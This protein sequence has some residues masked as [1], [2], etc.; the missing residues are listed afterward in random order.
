MSVTVPR[1]IDAVIKRLA[2]AS[3]LSR[4]RY[5]LMLLDAIMQSEARV[6]ARTT[7]RIDTD[8]A[9]LLARVAEARKKYAATPPDDTSNPAPPTGEKSATIYP[10][11]R[12]ARRKKD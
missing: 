4:N 10:S 5:M 3:G 12:S 2:R 11:A 6:E 9:P 7:I 1:E 8:G